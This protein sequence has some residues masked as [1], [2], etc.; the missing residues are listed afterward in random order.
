MKA[1]IFVNMDYNHEKM[2][3]NAIG[4]EFYRS[5][6]SNEIIQD[7]K[8]VKEAKATLKQAWEKIKPQLDD[9]EPSEG[10]NKKGNKIMYENCRIV[11]VFHF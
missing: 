3:T 5:K 1:M 11:E 10:L 7:F 2:I 4:S 8:T 9:L 6:N